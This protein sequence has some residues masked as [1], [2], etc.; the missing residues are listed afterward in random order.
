MIAAALAQASL[1]GLGA[2]GATS[3]SSI[4]VPGAARA[5]MAEARHNATIRIALADLM[6]VSPSWR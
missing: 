4:G 3:V 6:S 5:G 1:A 2:A